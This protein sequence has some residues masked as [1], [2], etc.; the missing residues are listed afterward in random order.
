MPAFAQHRKLLP[1]MATPASSEA[2]DVVT[3]DRY[4]VTVRQR[5]NRLLSAQ[6]ESAAASAAG[7][8]KTVATQ[9]P[10]LALSISASRPVSRP[11]SAAAVAA[12][13][14]PSVASPAATNYTR[15]ASPNPA[16]TSSLSQPSCAAD[17]RG[18]GS[19]EM[20]IRT[21]RTE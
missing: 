15:P 7:G 16:C 11:S 4:D 3:I 14:S 10:T 20:R 18:S 6:G 2:P 1:T 19:G 21:V 5:A 12:T 13:R 17:G 9:A 8:V